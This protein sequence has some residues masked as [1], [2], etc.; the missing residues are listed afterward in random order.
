MCYY[1]LAFVASCHYRYLMLFVAIHHPYL[2]LV[3]DICCCSTS[4]FVGMCCYLLP[5]WIRLGSHRWKPQCRLKGNSTFS[6][7]V[8]VKSHRRY[9]FRDHDWIPGDCRYIYRQRWPIKWLTERQ[10][11]ETQPWHG[12]Q[13]CSTGRLSR[14][15][16]EWL[17]SGPKSYPCNISIRFGTNAWCSEARVQ[18]KHT[19]ATRRIRAR[20][21]HLASWIENRCKIHLAS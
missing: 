9:V 3:V 19:V 4:L 18:R 17:V 12:T 13:H 8:C 11:V 5:F 6:F 14:R 20:K 7:K 1:L 2:P 10:P 16:G 21:I 15:N